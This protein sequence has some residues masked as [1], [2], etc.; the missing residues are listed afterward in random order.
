MCESVS[1]PYATPLPGIGQRSHLTPTP[2]PQRGIPP[3]SGKRRTSDDRA[4]SYDKRPMT[5]RPVEEGGSEADDEEEDIDKKDSPEVLKN[6]VKG[7]GSHSS[8]RQLSCATKARK[9]LSRD[10]NPPIEDFLEAGILTPLLPLMQE[11]DNPKLQFEATWALTN[12]ASGNSKQTA[13]VVESGS[14]PILVK[15]L[16]SSEGEVREQAAWALGNIAGDGPKSR[17]AVL[18]G[19]ILQPLINIIEAGEQE[20]P[21]K[22]STIRVVAW[23]L[24]NI[25]RNKNLTLTPEELK[26]SIAALKVLVNYRDE[27]VN[28]DALW[29]LSYLSEQGDEE[30]EGVLRED[31]LPVIVRHLGSDR[32]QMIV[33]ALRASGNI[34][35][36]NDL[37]TEAALAAGVLPLYKQLLRNTRRNIRKETAWA[38]SNVTAGTKRQIQQV[39]DEDLLLD[40]VRVI[41]EGFLDVQK[42][43][44]WALSNLTSGGTPSQIEALVAAGG[45]EALVTVLGVF[46]TSVVTV[47]LEGL[48]NI[49]AECGDKQAIV[50]RIAEAG[51]KEKLEILQR[52]TD[53][54]VSGKAKGLLEMHFDNTRD[55][56][57]VSDNESQADTLDN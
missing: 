47:A 38:L 17:D 46:E 8:S 19:G 34:V 13:A 55:N 32:S 54:T 16:E 28:V 51:G 18:L 30:I 3:T 2:L 40:L 20:G 23:V 57:D 37:Q 1:R 24:A 15:L 5:G 26:E 42:E 25:F 29:A 44:T 41:K 10:S 6:I 50:H 39:V 7:L 49:L 22:V 45:V 9:M 35:S 43:A 48:D 33:P 27:E 53:E 52:N 11:N 12:I 56:S 31:L 21:T 4:E 14:I 36:G